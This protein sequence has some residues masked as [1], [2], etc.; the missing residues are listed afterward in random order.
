MLEFGTLDWSVFAPWTDF[1]LHKLHYISLAF[2]VVAYAIKIKQ[3]L[4]KPAAGEGTPPKGDHATAIRYSYLLIAMPW[5]I[6]SQRKHWYRYVEFALFHIA[7]AVGIGVAFTMP[8]GHQY[9]T[10][11]VV[12]YALVAVFGLGTLIGL[13]R[14]AR[15]LTDPAMRSISKPDDYFCIMLLTLWMAS[16]VVMAPQVAWHGELW[17]QAYF[18]LATFFLFYVPFS[19]ISH[20]V[21]WPFMR[22]YIGKHFGHR[23]VFPKKRVASS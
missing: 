23:G 8:W 1:L 20:Y 7:M 4:D 22:F 6:E 12:I 18:V 2:M 13:S 15:R 5:E 14:L 17:V 3:L 19:K 21:Y 9:L 11:P 10:A 16:G